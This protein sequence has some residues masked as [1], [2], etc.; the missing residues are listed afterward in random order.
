MFYQ[1]R[2]RKTMTLDKRFV[3]SEI[4]ETLVGVWEVKIEYSYYGMYSF[5]ESHIENSIDKAI[6]WLLVQRCG[7]DKLRITNAEGLNI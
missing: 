4:T 7:D 6:R 3:K 5:T 2:Y 1:L